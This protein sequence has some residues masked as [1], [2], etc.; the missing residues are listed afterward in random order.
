MFVETIL[1]GGCLG[2][3]SVIDYINDNILGLLS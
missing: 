1:M 3:N 2:F